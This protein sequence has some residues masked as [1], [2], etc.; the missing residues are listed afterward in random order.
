[1]LKNILN[2][3]KKLTWTKAFLALFVLFLLGTTAI[4]IKKH[5]QVPSYDPSWYL[6]YSEIFYHD[7]TEHGAKA[8]A[9]DFITS[10]RIKAPLISVLPI[11]FYPI[12]GNSENTAYIPLMLCIIIFNLYLFKLVKHFRSEKEAAFACVIAS[13]FPVVFAMTREFFVEYPLMTAVTAWIY[14]LVKS[15]LY[16]IKKYNIVLG[17]LAGLGMLLKVLFPLFIFVPAIYALAV[18]IKRDGWLNRK[19]FK[20]IGLIAALGA[21]ISATWYAKNL[22][23]IAMFTLSNSVGSVAKDYSMGSVFSLDTIW[24][25]W[26]SIIN[27]DFSVYWTAVFAGFLMLFVFSVILNKRPKGARFRIQKEYLII[28]L[29]WFLFPALLCTFG[30]NKASRFLMPAYPAFAAIISMVIFAVLKKNRFKMTILVALI[31]F[32][33]FNYLYISFNLNRFPLPWV[34]ITK[35]GFVLVSKE[36][37]AIGAPKQEYWPIEEI[38]DYIY[39]DSIQE[40]YHT[41]IAIAPSIP[42]FNHNNFRYYAAM[43]GYRSLDFG[44]LPRGDFDATLGRFLDGDYAIIKRGGSPGPDWLNQGNEQLTA[45]LDQ[46]KLNMYKYLRS[47]ELPDGGTAEVWRKDE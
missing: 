33:V 45:F 3:H 47:F 31:V 41:F 21:L 39:R 19:F 32:P 38:V 44:G 25:Y 22:P 15:D 29:S 16:R 6:E 43:K 46:N 11:P 4:Y 13:T 2:L 12:F 27:Y 9:R 1:M 20:D 18:R 17:I 37:P 34:N 40:K 35:K 24:R 23:F 5:T 30:V 14:Y 36:I 42:E 8:F 28:I 10:F 26:K 7:L